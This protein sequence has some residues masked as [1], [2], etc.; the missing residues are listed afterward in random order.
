MNQNR[1]EIKHVTGEDLLE[2]SFPLR[3]YAFAPSPRKTDL[4]AWRRALPSQ[5]EHH[6]L[7]LFADGAPRATATSI[8]M[9][10]AVRG[11]VLSMGGVAGVATH[12]LGRRQGYAWQV[13][14]RL[15]QDMRDQGHA[16]SSLGPFRESF[17]G[18]LGWAGFPAPRV[19]QFAPVTLQPLLRWDLPGETT[20]HDDEAGLTALRAFLTR[21][22]PAVH[23]MSLRGPTAA[24]GQF[25]HEMRWIVLARDGEEVVGAMTYSISDWRGQLD[26]DAFFAETAA[27]SYLLLRWLA[28]HADQVTRITLTLPPD[29]MPELWVTDLNAEVHSRDVDNH[30]NPMGR[31]VDITRID[32]IGA[33]DGR[34]SV[35][36]EDEYAPWNT[37]TYTFHGKGGCLRVEAADPKRATGAISM[38]G[39][40]A[41]IF[42]GT[43][44][45]TFA[46]RGWG[47]I[48][49]PTREVMR[50]VFPP[51]WPYL[52][53]DF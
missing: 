36:I 25:D 39:L 17:Y 44:P 46:Y 22:Q 21:V 31:I 9:T 29:V 40:S 20:L 5:Q 4:D 10:Q 53:E 42:N 18:R 41:L 16:V 30:P 38:A 48:D 43:D 35:H 13:L 34:F 12:P 15:L 1:I 3:G 33:G 11:R 7:V 28:L 32:G 51:A 26:V 37:G 52:H 2:T 50:A 45:D 8:A 6:T 19:I 27:G 24:A 49:R 47:N 23:G 14:V